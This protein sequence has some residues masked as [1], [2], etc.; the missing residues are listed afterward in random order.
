MAALGAMPMP[1]GFRYREVFL[2]GKPAHDRYDAF[3]VRHPQMPASR[4][5]K[6]FAPFEALRGFD[7]ALAG[8][9][10]AESAPGEPVRVPAEEAP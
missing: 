8:I 2:R 4:R 9:R 10:S 1:A 6:I 5:A 3:R 7:E